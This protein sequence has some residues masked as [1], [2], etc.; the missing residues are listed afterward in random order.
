[1]MHRAWFCTDGKIGLLIY[2]SLL[3]HSFRIALLPVNLR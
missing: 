2:V 3:G 1:M